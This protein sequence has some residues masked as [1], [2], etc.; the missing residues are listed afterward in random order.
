MTKELEASKPAETWAFYHEVQ[1]WLHQ[2]QRY[3][4]PSARISRSAEIIGQVVVSAD[5]VIM[6]HA[7]VQGPAILGR[8]TVLGHSAMVRPGTVLGD[9]ALLGNSCY[10]NAALM[11]AASR[12]GHFCGVS[13]SVLHAG[14][15]FSAFVMTAT[16]RPDYGPVETDD[17]KEVAK[18]GCVVGARTTIAPH[19]TIPRGVTIGRECF[20]GSYVRLAHDLPPKMRATADIAVRIA[21]NTIETALRLP[22]D[23]PDFPT[24][25]DWQ[26]TNSQGTIDT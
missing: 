10:A 26:A 19:V 17:N 13:R 6:P 4:A 24:I 8:A 1:S 22:T 12:L 15:Y 21:P 16:T 23:F 5:A 9:N 2:L 7:S 14:T 3:I 20:V 18:R 11:G 25:S